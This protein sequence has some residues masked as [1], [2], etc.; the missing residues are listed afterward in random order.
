MNGSLGRANRAAGQDRLRS[1]NGANRA[2]GFGPKAAL[3]Q[4][5]PGARIPT[6]NVRDHRSTG[7]GDVLAGGSG[8]PICRASLC[9]LFRQRAA[10]GCRRSRDSGASAC[11]CADQAPQRPRRASRPPRDCLARDRDASRR[12]C[13]RPRRP[14]AGGAPQRSSRAN[15]RRGPCRPQRPRAVQPLLVHRRAPAQARLPPHRD[16]AIPVGKGARRWKRCTPQSSGAG[17][18]A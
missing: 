18:P 2:G 16:R 17:R 9:G 3:V 12:S 10:R 7:A 14:Q 11:L 4:F 6:L 5:D 8:A 13:H 1:F 15:P